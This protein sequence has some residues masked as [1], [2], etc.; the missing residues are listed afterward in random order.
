MTHNNNN[1]INN[2]I[3]SRLINQQDTTTNMP[4]SQIEFTQKTTVKTSQT[5]SKR[6][7]ATSKVYMNIPNTR[8]KHWPEWRE[9]NRYIKG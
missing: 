1:N 7:K 2:N 3:N 9:S 6:R 4:L 8:R 5:K